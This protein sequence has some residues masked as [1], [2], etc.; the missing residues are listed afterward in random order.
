MANCGASI[1][2]APQISPSSLQSATLPVRFGYGDSAHPTFA[3]G[4]IGS[5]SV[6]VAGL[7]MDNQF[8]AACDQTNSNVS[9]VGL[10][11]IFGAGFPTPFSSN[12]I[13]SG[14]QTALLV[15]LWLATGWS[16]EI[17]LL[18]LMNQT[19]TTDTD[20]FIS[21]LPSQGPLLPR[22]IVNGQLKEPMFTVRNIYFLYRFAMSPYFLCFR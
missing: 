13:L 6:G 1:S 3:S 12:V 18:A 17:Q 14:E 22:L 8:L 19:G 5:G 11:G 15:A 4:V 10:S 9:D 20:A 16:N 21:K 7:K 2:S